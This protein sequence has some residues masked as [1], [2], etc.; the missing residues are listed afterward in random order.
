VMRTSLLPGLVEAAARAR[1]HG[2]Q[3]IRLFEVG[4]SFHPVA[5]ETLPHEHAW[6]ALMLL[7]ARSPWFGQERAL[8]FFDAKGHVE[9][10]VESLLGVRVEVALDDT[11]DTRAPFLHPRRRG[12]VRI[13]GRAVGVIGELHPDVVDAT[14]LEGR[15]IYAELDM[16]TLLELSLTVTPQTAVAPPRFPATT[17]DLALLVDESVPVGA[18]RDIMLAS[19][20]GL[21]ERVELFDEYRGE[22]VPAGKR[23]LAF[24]VVYRDK[25]ATLT[26]ARVEAAHAVVLRALENGFGAVRR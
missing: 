6:L 2:A 11:L 24:R 25:E 17:L 1:R 23:S 10:I 3:T 26:D 19:S 5:G 14:S 13:V 8:D 18:L 7:G 15:G 21:V 4:R 22:H 9:A 16:E 20:N 12:I